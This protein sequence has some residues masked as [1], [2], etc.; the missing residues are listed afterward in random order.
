MNSKSVGNNYE[1]EMSKILSEWFT[2]NK[3]ELVVWRHVS[4]GSIGTIRKN[5]GLSGKNVDGDFQCLD[6]KYSEFFKL[7]Y[8]DSK[9]LSDVNLFVINPKNQKSNQLLNEWKKVVN[10]AGDKL[11][12]MFVK[13]RKNRSVPD[14]IL[15]HEN[16]KVQGNYFIG[17]SLQEPKYD[18][19]LLMQDD[20]FKCNNWFDLIEKNT[21]I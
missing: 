12:L 11:P 17:F 20:F 7:F 5:K 3:D 18:F 1:R 21:K 10:D 4:S 16:I 19:I 13:L 6:L 2:G 8:M 15:L 9:S 14:F